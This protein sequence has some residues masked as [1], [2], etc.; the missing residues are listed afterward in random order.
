MVPI[1]EKAEV[2]IKFTNLSFSSIGNTFFQGI[3]TPYTVT[4]VPGL[5]VTHLPGPNRYPGECLSGPDFDSVRAELGPIESCESRQH[6]GCG[7]LVRSTG[8]RFVWEWLGSFFRGTPHYQGTL[9]PRAFE[10]F[11][12]FAGSVAFPDSNKR[13]PERTLEPDNMIVVCGRECEKRRAMR[14]DTPSFGK[15]TSAPAGWIFSTQQPAEP[16]VSI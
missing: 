7:C 10:A 12:Q 14:N 13:P 5:F 16:T 3:L 9:S 6:F 15:L 8:H 4:Y 2:S 11:L 1:G